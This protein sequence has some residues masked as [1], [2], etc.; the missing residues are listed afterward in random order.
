MLLI[1]KT[2]TAAEVQSAI[3]RVRGV[4]ASRVVAED[5]AI[6]EVHILAETSRSAKQIVRDVESLC[7]AQF[8]IELDHRKVSVALI[9]QTQG[10][11]R[12]IRRPEIRGVRV[13]TEGRRD[14]S[15][16]DFGCWRDDDPG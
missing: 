13:E 11:R 6:S 2:P 8:G 4:M 12:Q 10:D 1:Q 14:P 5:G 3:E 9:N 16:C 7:A 15:P